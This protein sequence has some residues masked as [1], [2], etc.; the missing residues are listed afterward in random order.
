MK[1]LHT[2]DWHI[3]QQFH[4]YSRHAEHQHFFKWL[5]QIIVQ[6]NIDVLLVSGD[7]FDSPNPS[8]QSQRIYYHFLSEVSHLSPHLQIIITAG[9]HDSASRIEAPEA[10]LESFGV[11]VRGNIKPQSATEKV[12]TPLIIPLKK[13]GKIK[14]CCLAVPYVRYGDLPEGV[15]SL[16]QLYHTLESIINN[17]STL[18]HVPL[19]VMG[20]LHVMGASLSENDKSERIIQGGLECVDYNVFPQRACYVALG[21]LHRPQ[22]VAGLE[23]IRYAGSPI[24]M[25]FS[26]KNYSHGV[27]IIHLESNTL[28]S[29]ERICYTPLAKL[30]SI[31]SRPQPL[32]EVLNEIEQLPLGEIV[33]SSPYLEVKVLEEEPEPDKRFRI[34]QAL[35]GRAVR[36]A[37]IK[38]I[39]KSSTNTSSAEQTLSYEPQH[40]TPRQLA[41]LVFEQRYGKPFPEELDHLLTQVI[42]E[43]Q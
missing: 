7:V 6:E 36:L 5:T 23:H 25:S 20:H 42:E 18:S 12:Y 43:L 17:S 21:H 32:S 14:A 28:S 24:P 22:K 39:I 31:P 35:A 19:I 1:I 3:G 9:N 26:E 10:L 29:I 30:V 40:T 4:G 27:N 8:A 15:T 34:E 33:D 37:S 13:E 11:V 41:H 2:A 38:A 16:A